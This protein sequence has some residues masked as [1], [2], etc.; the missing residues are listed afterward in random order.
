MV[1]DRRT[2]TLVSIDTSAETTLD[3]EV[4]AER[5]DEIEVPFDVPAEVIVEVETTLLTITIELRNEEFWVD[6][7]VA[8]LATV[9]TPDD[10]LV[11]TE[12]L[13]ETCVTSP[14]I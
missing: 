5:T 13:L 6:A 12:R 7:T 4:A 3:T 14:E 8:M 2:E 11:S 1:V 9:E 10:V